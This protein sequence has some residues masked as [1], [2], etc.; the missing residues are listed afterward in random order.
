VSVP[1]R[2]MPLAIPDVKLVEPAVHG[3]ARGFF[4]ETFK[5]SD[6]A[7]HGLPTDFVQ[8]SQSRNVG[9]G[10]LRGLHYQLPPAA[11]GK[12]VRCA[13]GR[14][15]DVALDVRRGSPTFG[16]HVAHELSGDAQQMLWIPPGFAHGYATL[17]DVCD[18]H[19]KMT[20]SEWSKAHE[21]AVRWDDPALGIVWRVARPLLSEKDAKAPLLKDA[22]VFP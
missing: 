6:F 3:D 9:A 12:L 11:Q 1:L 4:A 10:T 22:E 13:A 21:R 16:R 15:L 8:D 20:G 18:M 19:Y 5:R 17:S 14:C 2:V 7:S